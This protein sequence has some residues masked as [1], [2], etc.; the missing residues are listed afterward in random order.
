MSAGRARNAHPFWYRTLRRLRAWRGGG[1]AKRHQVHFMRLGEL[2][3]KRVRLADACEAARIE[4]TLEALDGLSIVP[5]LV[6]RADH[7]LL[8]EYVPGQPPGRRATEILAQLGAF[9]ATLYQRHARRVPLQQTPWPLRLQRDLRVL[10]QAGIFPSAII[11]RIQARALEDAPESV[12]IG[13]DYLDPLPKNFVVRDGELVAIDAEALHAD[14]LLGLGPAK[15]LA[16][17]P[18]VQAGPLL[19]AIS[20]AGGPDLGPQLR[21]ARICFLAEY[22]KQKRFQGKAHLAP[23]KLLEDWLGGG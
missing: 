1:A 21:Y 2:Q 5:P 20:A 19:E 8:F 22:S 4:Q 12:R 9:F 23:V 6:L 15:V 18:D 3:C 17:W 14:S 11:A 7:E 10:D 13:Y 16:R